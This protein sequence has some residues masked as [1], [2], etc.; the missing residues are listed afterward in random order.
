M[1][2]LA[3]S[4][5]QHDRINSCLNMYPVTYKGNYN[6]RRSAETA[7]LTG[8]TCAMGIITQLAVLSIVHDN[9]NHVITG[10]LLMVIYMMSKC[11]Q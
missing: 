3:I 4:P 8:C 1:D 2:W 9:Q 6:Y 10:S 7:K 11:L 5:T